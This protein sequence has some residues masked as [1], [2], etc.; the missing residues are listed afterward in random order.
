MRSRTRKLL[1]GISTLI[2]VTLLVMLGGAL[3]RMVL[4][5][6]HQRDWL[7]RQKG[8][9]AILKAEL[10]LT[11]STLPFISRFLP[12]SFAFHCLPHAFLR[13]QSLSTV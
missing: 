2:A 12:T 10:R 7:E 3:V 4:T 8:A 9:V 6:G 13:V 5:R 11:P 1:I